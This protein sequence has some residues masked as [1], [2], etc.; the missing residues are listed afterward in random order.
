MRLH[1]EKGEGSP[2]S[3]AFFQSLEEECRI[4]L[5]LSDYLS[6]KPASRLRSELALEL[7][8]LAGNESKD[9]TVPLPSI[10]LPRSNPCCAAA[11]VRS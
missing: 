4:H 2:P 1:V 11:V 3:P 7:A 6:W 5:L 10:V 9:A 8:S